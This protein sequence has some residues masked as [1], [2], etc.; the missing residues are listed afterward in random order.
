MNK[1]WFDY[2]LPIWALGTIVWVTAGCILFPDSWSR[3]V[4][5]TDW[6]LEQPAIFDVT[7]VDWE[8]ARQLAIVVG[9][10]VVS[11]LV[12]FTIMAAQRIA[13]KRRTPPPFT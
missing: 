4:F 10:T 9:P 8:V 5:S 7:S 2:F 3:P 6:A 13:E 1:N 11:F 12:A